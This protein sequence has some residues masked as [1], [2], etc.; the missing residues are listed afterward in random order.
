MVD[1]RI[2]DFGLVK[3]RIVGV[4]LL[5]VGGL[6]IAVATSV[7]HHGGVQVGGREAMEGV[8]QS[9]VEEAHKVGSD[10]GHWV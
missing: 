10:V 3:G 8:G 5:D 2:E 6:W 4:N 7:G 1:S 9:V